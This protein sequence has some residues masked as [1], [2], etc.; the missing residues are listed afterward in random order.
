MIRGA[1]LS[2]EIGRARL[3]LVTPSRLGFLVAKYAEVALSG[4]V[5]LG[6]APPEATALLENGLVAIRPEQADAEIV[7]TVERAL[8]DPDDLR[9]RSELL[10]ARFRSRC[11][12][13]RY[14]EKLLR[15]VSLAA[16]RESEPGDDADRSP[17]GRP[18]L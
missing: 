14:A 1:D 17:E 13:A 8:A 3:A 16:G 6:N 7:A 11:D 12:S 5:P 18:I 15:I 9:R 4:A 10:G 2:R